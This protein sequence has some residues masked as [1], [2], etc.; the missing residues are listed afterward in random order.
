MKNLFLKNNSEVLQDLGKDIRKARIE[1]NM[2]QAELSNHSGVSVHS[3]SNI[4]NGKDFSV[5]N[6]ISILRSLSLL[7]N[8][9]LL[10]PNI[11]PNPYDIAKGIND[12][13]RVYRK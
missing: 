4:E 10:I 2:S 12:R 7:E 3:I 5:D 9:S 1:R 6:L 11:A 8:L 13:S